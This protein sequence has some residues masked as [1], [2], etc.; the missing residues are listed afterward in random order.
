MK[1]KKQKAQK[2]CLKK[3][4]YIEDYRNCLEAIQLDKK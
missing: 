4:K 3:K 2:V 1:A